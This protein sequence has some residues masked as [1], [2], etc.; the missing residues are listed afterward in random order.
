MPIAKYHKQRRVT[1]NAWK[2]RFTVQRINYRGTTKGAAIPTLASISPTTVVHGG[3]NLTVT[4]TGTGF[5]SGL[6]KATVNGGDVAT[7]YVSATSCTCVVPSTMMLSAT[8]L[9]IGVHNADQVAT[10]TKTLTVT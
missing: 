4:L 2:K 5:I 1:R 7:T 9:T 10:A 6:T 8:T 3:A